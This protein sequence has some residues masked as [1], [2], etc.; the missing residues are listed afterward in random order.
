MLF[1]V[2]FNN[3]PEFVFVDAENVSQA[4]QTV[5]TLEPV[6]SVTRINGLQGI[7]DACYEDPD[8][9][10]AALVEALPFVLALHSELQQDLVRTLISNAAMTEPEVTGLLRARPSKNVPDSRYAYRVFYGKDNQDYA[11]CYGNDDIEAVEEFLR[12]NPDKT[13]RTVIPI[14]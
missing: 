6:Y 2:T 9:K 12:Y 8:S 4:V 1:K 11:V 14:K 10:V 5:G 7:L 3:T 13:V